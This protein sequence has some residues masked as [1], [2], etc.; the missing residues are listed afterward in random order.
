MS[1]K[2]RK[3]SVFS[4]RLD[5]L[6]DYLKAYQ[7]SLRALISS[8]SQG[9]IEPVAPDVATIG[10][11]DV[12]P[13][14]DGA[15]V[16]IYK[17][18]SGDISIKKKMPVN[19]S[20]NKFLKENEAVLF[21]DSEGNR[22]QFHPS[23]RFGD[24]SKVI[25]HI[26]E[27]RI[28]SGREEY[29]TKY[30]RAIIVGSKAKLRRPDQEAIRDFR[31]A[32]AMKNIGS[33]A[34]LGLIQ[35]EKEDVL[36]IKAQELVAEFENLLEKA[37]NEEELQKFLIEHPEFL[38]P[39]YIKKLPKFKLGDDYVTDYVFLTQGV[40]GREYVFVEIEKADKQ[41]FTAKSGQFSHEFTQ[42]KD[43]LLKWD[44]W[45][46]N[47]HA[48]VIQKLPELYKPKYHLI[49]GR[50][51]SLTEEQRNKL[52]TEFTGTDRVFSTY[53]DLVKHFQQIVIR[54]T[55]PDISD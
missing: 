1:K 25:F 33:S 30:Q 40:S 5:Q 19:K 42:A 41:I 50:G 46:S 21:Y 48:Y 32:Y 22:F 6:I 13:C 16:L 11:V 52:K 47:N 10:K 51:H 31:T 26:A 39:D 43:Q 24:V 12:W 55:S 28:K 9:D 35:K 27:S 37:K 18:T 38:Y 34:L 53:D 20:V 54:L 23:F 36:R 29:R 44:E 7:H 49:M 45:I 3:L 17:S 4:S 15:V 2:R 14:K 8:V